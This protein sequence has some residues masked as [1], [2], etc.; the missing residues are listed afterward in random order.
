[1]EEESLKG[2]SA[3]DLGSILSS[4]LSLDP[5][6]RPSSLPNPPEEPSLGP[7][8]LH[9]F[10]PTVPREK[11][12]YLKP[13]K[14]AENA[15]QFRKETKT[16]SQP[17]KS[18]IRTP[19]QLISANGLSS[20]SEE[21][22]IPK[23]SANKSHDEIWKLK[24]DIRDIHYMMMDGDG[25]AITELFSSKSKLRRRVEGLG[26]LRSGR[27][28]FSKIFE[29]FEESDD[30]YGIFTWQLV[31]VICEQVI[32]LVI[33]HRDEVFLAN[34]VAD[35]LSKSELRGLR[36]KD[37]RRLLSK[38]KKN[39]GLDDG[40]RKAFFWKSNGAKVLQAVLD[41]GEK[42]AS[43]ADEDEVGKFKEIVS[44]ITLK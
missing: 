4:A 2:I 40:K 43:T 14:Y 32:Y 36:L 22:N 11:R 29:F 13:S 3:P 12:T 15:E 19:K 6:K 39:A 34:K 42:L 9:R 31:E 38:I 10:L 5:L 20:D 7:Y 23:A 44:L 17:R 25:Q 24:K 26:W 21:D 37:V 30:D 35:V 27:I 33:A 28:L 18:N 16:L 1:M 8:S 41:L